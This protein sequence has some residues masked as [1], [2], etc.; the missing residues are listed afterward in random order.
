MFVNAGVIIASKAFVGGIF[1]Y[2]CAVFLL[3][4]ED[5]VVQTKI[6]SQLTSLFSLNVNI[7]NIY[8]GLEVK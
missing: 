4:F 3:E 8:C 6:N 7:I 2:I 5:Q 1:M